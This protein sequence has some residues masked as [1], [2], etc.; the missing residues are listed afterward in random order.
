MWPR[1]GSAK[2]DLGSATSAVGKPLGSRKE[3]LTYGLASQ[4]DATTKAGLVKFGLYVANYG[5]FSNVRALGGLAR[6][7]EVGGW[8]GIFLFDSIQPSEAGSYE[9][10]ADPWLALMAIALATERIRFGTLVTALARRRPAKLAR[11]TVTLDQASGGRLVLGVGLGYGPSAGPEFAGFGEDPDPVVRAAKLDEGL[12]VLIGLW[13]GKPFSHTG[14]YYQVQETTFLPSPVQTPRIPIWVAGF[15]PN[16][17]PLRRAARYDG[18]FP[19]HL[20]WAGG[21]FLSPEEI[22]SIRSYVAERRAGNEPFDVVFSAG[23]PDNQPSP[24][25]AALAAY[26]EAGVTWWLENATSLEQARAR[27]WEGPTAVG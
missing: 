2:G 23:Y 24:T 4:D 5:D 15:W 20:D 1:P 12:E 19:L 13:S 16:R 21:S 10:V 22:R 17:R 9:P 8:D 18:V 25:A 6:E 3:I 7:A 11:E 27:A 14:R 26:A